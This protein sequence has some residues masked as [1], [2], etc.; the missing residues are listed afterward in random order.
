[1]VDSTSMERPWWL[2]AFLLPM[3]CGGTFL[4]VVIGVGGG[5]LLS[6][7]FLGLGSTPWGA[8]FFGSF[9]GLSVAVPL[10]MVADRSARRSEACA[11]HD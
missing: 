1:M 6:G 2:L 10:I 8:L 5:G 7:L 11:T 4:A 3:C 9:M